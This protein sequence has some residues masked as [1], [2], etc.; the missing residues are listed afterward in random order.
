MHIFRSSQ[1]GMNQ[2]QFIQRFSYNNLDANPLAANPLLK[3]NGTLRDASVLIP[4]YADQNDL[5]VVLTKRAAHLK[6]HPGQV[7]FPGGKV[8]PSDGTLINTALR[9][10]EEEI[11]LL[12]E[13][14]EIVGQL[15]RYP[16]I[17]GYEITPIIGLI[18]KDYVFTPDHNEVAEV[19]TVPLQHFLNENNHY[20]IQ[21]K[22][23]GINHT[24]H[25]MPYLSYNIWGATAAILKDL[26]LHVK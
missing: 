25:F 4:I 3:S 12:R 6:H 2:Q 15:T 26:V 5:H 16:T 22:Q 13:D 17:S 19:F 9:E 24:V 7:S 21:V 1:L 10:S 8:E 20:N 11:G 14:V 18:P 23:R